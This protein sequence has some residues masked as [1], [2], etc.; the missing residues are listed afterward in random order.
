MLSDTPLAGSDGSPLLPLGGLSDNLL[1]SLDDDKIVTRYSDEHGFNNPEGQWHTGN[2][3]VMAVGDSFTFGA[4]VPFGHSFMDLVRTKAGSTVNLGCGGNGPLSELAALVEYGPLL[5]PKT[6]V[7]VYYEGNDLTKDLRRELRSPVLAR[8][9]EEDFTQQLANRQGEINAALTN[10]LEPRLAKI[11]ET[12]T[13]PN[14]RSAVALPDILRLT[15]LRTTVGLT[16]G[17]DRHR[18]QLVCDFDDAALARF[19]QILDTAAKLIGTW[20][21]R[22]VFVYLPGADRYT[23]WFANVDA[24]GARNAVLRVV[25][26]L[27]IERVDI[28][29]AFLRHADPRALFAGHF[30]KEGNRLV[31]GTI[32]TRLRS[33]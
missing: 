18:F 20:H 10:F 15:Q 31:A 6:V 22:F 16:C 30:N 19:S 8:Y 2:V 25:E 24:D 11:G 26:E 5:R 9:L 13:T 17:F 21:G 23:N 7:W 28:H 32:L 29:T 4:D 3:E 33:E 14:V 12:A 1:I 27:G